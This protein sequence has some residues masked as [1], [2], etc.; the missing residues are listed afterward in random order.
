MG[1][2]IAWMSNY[3]FNKETKSNVCKILFK[4]DKLNLNQGGYYIST[5]VYVDLKRADWLQSAI[6]FEVIDG[7]FYNAGKGVPVAESR[8]LFDFDV[9]F[10]SK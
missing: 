9:N 6:Y 2:R 10:I 3:L 4:M 1:Q 5:D 7:D 8:L